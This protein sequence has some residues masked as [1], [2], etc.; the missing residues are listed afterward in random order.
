M[1]G[2]EAARI[3]RTMTRT[4]SPHQLVTGGDR[5]ISHGLELARDAIQALGNM[6]TGCGILNTDIIAA[7]CNMVS[8]WCVEVVKKRF[9]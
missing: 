8:M 5:R 9:K 2:I 4:I 6:K 1:T 3:R 7:F